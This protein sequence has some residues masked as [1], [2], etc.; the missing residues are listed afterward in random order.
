MKIKFILLLPLYFL[1][2]NCN[3]KVKSVFVESIP[4]ENINL[5]NR[6]NIDNTI[7]TEG[8]IFIYSHVKTKE[9]S[10]VNSNIKNLEIEILNDMRHFINY[11][12][13][14]NQTVMKITYLDSINNVLFV[15]RT[16]IIENENNIW[17]HP[18]RSGDLEILQMSSFPYVKLLMP[19]NKKW[20]WELTASYKDYKNVLIEYDYVKTKKTKIDTKLGVLSGVCIISNTKS[21]IGKYK[22]EFIFNENYGFI[23]LDFENFD[24]THD[25]L[26]LEEV[27]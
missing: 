19:F 11:D 23:Y 18:P 9:G 10:I 2:N 26:K 3:N 17:L 5:D 4:K 6:Y 21:S 27:R 15:E 24:G 13:N 1:F 8:R 16:G 14:Y 12:E 22:S 25:I 7:Y 20:Y